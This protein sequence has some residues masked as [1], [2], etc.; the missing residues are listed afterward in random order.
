[1]LLGGYTCHCV[2]GWYGDNCQ[3]DHDEC[4]SNPCAISATCHVSLIIVGVCQCYSVTPPCCMPGYWEWVLLWVHGRLHWYHM[5]PRYHRL[6]CRELWHGSLPRELA[7]R[8]M[9]CFNKTTAENRI[10][11]HS[12]PTAGEQPAPW[13]WVWL[14]CWLH[15]R[16][17]WCRHWW[18]HPWSLH[19]WWHLHREYTC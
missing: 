6:H 13:F 17:M 5:W 4:G 15:W 2:P 9:H 7:L 14:W 11:I 1:M 16:H 19:E 12:P 18:M 3:V 10:S 8:Y